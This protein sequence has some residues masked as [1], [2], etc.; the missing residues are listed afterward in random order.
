MEP[1]R[2]ASFRRSEP[3]GTAIFAGSGRKRS[4]RGAGNAGLDGPGVHQFRFPHGLYGLLVWDTESWVSFIRRIVADRF[5]RRSLLMATQGMVAVLVLSLAAVQATSQVA[6]WQVYLG[7]FLLGGLQ[8]INTP[9]RLAIVADLVDRDDLM[10]A[11][12][13]NSAVM[14]SGRGRRGHR[15]WR[16]RSRRLLR[17][18]NRVVADGPAVTANHPAGRL[19]Y[20]QGWPDSILLVQPG[21]VY[22]YRDW[23]RI[24]VLRD[25]L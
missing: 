20:S 25:A 17:R 2:R 14:N 22:R 8:A 18:W 12:V 23:V 7:S 6:L 1:L 10:N 16:Y 13:L 3:Y 21:H 4:S 5:D 15:D 24:R 9:A 11:V 19:P